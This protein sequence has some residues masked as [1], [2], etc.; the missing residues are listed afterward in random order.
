[1]TGAANGHAF[2]SLLAVSHVDPGFALAAMVIARFSKE[3]AT[4][5][6]LCKDR[7][8]S[9]L[10]LQMAAVAMERN[11]VLLAGTGKPYDN[12]VGDMINVDFL[13]SACDL[14]GGKRW[15]AGGDSLAVLLSCLLCTPIVH[16]TPRLAT[17]TPMSDDACCARGGSNHPLGRPGMVDALLRQR[18]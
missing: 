16:I 5:W 11:V 6:D 4:V 7:V 14:M 1:M 17:H 13:M 2:T 10:S 15:H 9:L 3:G 18:R 12:A 8:N